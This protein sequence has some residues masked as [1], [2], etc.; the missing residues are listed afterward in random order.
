[1]NNSG[2]LRFFLCIHKNV[3][4]F[5]RNHRSSLAEVFTEPYGS[6]DTHFSGL[7]VS[8]MIHEVFY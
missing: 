2:L 6:C 8:Y 7:Q 4:K 1:M 3:V 5:D